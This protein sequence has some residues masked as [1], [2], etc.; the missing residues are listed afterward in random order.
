MTSDEELEKL[1]KSRCPCGGIILADTDD[2]K[3]PVCVE[4]AIEIS[5]AYLPKDQNYNEGFTAG[6]KSLA[7]R[8]PSDEDMAD[9]SAK[10][11]ES[12]TGGCWRSF[13][14]GANWLKQKLFGEK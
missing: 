6:V 1:V 14:S 7:E 11:L 3:V 13:L 8:W 9:A 2:C 12:Y 10:F 5:R 4:C